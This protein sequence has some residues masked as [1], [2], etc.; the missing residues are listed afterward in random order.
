VWQPNSS[1]WR[2]IWILAIVIVLFWPGAQDRSLTVKAL[3]WV[4]DPRDKLPRLPGEFSFT[5]GDDPF[6]VADHDAQEAEYYRVYQ[7]SQLARLRMRLRDAPDPFDPSTQE[8]VLVAMG[9]LGAVLIW[10]LGGR[11]ARG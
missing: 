10:R 8:Q 3:N 2:V 5:D 4:A 11:P 6:A 9:V 1:Q 7:S